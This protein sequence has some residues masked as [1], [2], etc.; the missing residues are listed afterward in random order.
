MVCEWNE[1]L[2]EVQESGRVNVHLSPELPSS[3]LPSTTPLFSCPLYLPKR[4]SW[5]LPTEG[6]HGT[7]SKVR[8]ESLNHTEISLNL[9]F[10][11]PSVIESLFDGIAK[12]VLVFVVSK[13]VLVGKFLVLLY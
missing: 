9:V 1:T 5:P 6:E 13:P 10:Y 3:A 8:N 4:A 2:S 7:T 11:L 12:S